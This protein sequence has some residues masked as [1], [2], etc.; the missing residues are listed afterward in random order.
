MSMNV[1]INDTTCS[2][3]DPTSVAQSGCYIA[4]LDG[5]FS[6]Y[7]EQDN[8]ARVRFYAAKNYYETTSKNFYV[9][10]N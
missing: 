8:M 4:M 2:T 7:F 5:V 3:F 9:P 6:L 1:R 10:Y